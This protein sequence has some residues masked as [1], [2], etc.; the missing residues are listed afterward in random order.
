MQKNVSR[1]TFLLSHIY[2]SNRVPSFYLK[3]CVMLDA[4]TGIESQSWI[5]RL[6]GDSM[7]C[8]KILLPVR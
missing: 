5:L 2:P 4:L 7:K 6:K 8:K 1:E 3:C